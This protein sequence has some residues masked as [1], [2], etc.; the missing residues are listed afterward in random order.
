[1]GERS[2]TFRDSASITSIARMTNIGSISSIPSVA[3]HP[4]IPSV[5][6]QPLMGTRGTEVNSGGRLPL[7]GKGEG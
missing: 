4:S 2:G 3:Q 1:M 5:A 6:Q 7:A